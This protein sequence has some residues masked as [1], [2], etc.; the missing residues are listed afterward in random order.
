MLPSPVERALTDLG[1]NLRIARKRRRET[2]QSF[3]ERMQVSV[4]TLRKMESG[5]P[6][7]SISVYAMALWLVGRVQFLSRIADPATDETALALELQ[8]LKSGSKGVQR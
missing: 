3:A 5:D 1:E 8:N 2:M 7:V 4:P 6:T